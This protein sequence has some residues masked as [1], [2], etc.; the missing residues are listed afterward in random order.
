MRVNTNINL[1]EMLYKIEENRNVKKVIK[2]NKTL[3]ENSTNVGRKKGHKVKSIFD[4]DKKIILKL[5]KDGVSNTKII[6]KIGVGT[7]QGLGKYIKQI[8]ELQKIKSLNNKTAKQK[9]CGSIIIF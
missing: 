5:H 1:I 3:K 2:R 8:E 4:K 6:D 9:N 7:P